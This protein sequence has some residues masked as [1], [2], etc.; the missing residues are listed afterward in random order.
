[1]LEKEIVKKEP[2]H[3]VCLELVLIVE[4]LAFKGD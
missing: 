2:S 1:M 4:Q 3:L